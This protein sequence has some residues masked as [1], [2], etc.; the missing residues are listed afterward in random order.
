MQFLNQSDQCILRQS[1]AELRK[2]VNLANALEIW[3][4]FRSNMSN[5]GIFRNVCT[6]Q[7]L[8]NNL[9]KIFNQHLFENVAF[10]EHYV[11]LNM[12]TMLLCRHGCS[13]Q[14]THFG[15]Q[16]QPAL[17]VQ[18]TPLHFSQLWDYLQP[19]VQGH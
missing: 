11:P 17:L 2:V 16:Y 13:S 14:F 1:E 10:G 6:F 12:K 19:L 4:T 9:E 8:E 18:R 3:G 7:Y 5:L 15:E